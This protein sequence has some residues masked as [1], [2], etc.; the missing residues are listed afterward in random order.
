MRP[1]A[2]VIASSILLGFGVLS[3]SVGDG[4]HSNVGIP[5][6]FFLCVVGLFLFVKNAW[7]RRGPDA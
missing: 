6:G 2:Y 5:G 7:N 4:T 3:M 1:E